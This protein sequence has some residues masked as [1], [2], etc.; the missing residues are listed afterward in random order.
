MITYL[1]RCRYGVQVKDVELLVAFLNDTTYS[2]LMR[3][4]K[5]YYDICVY[6]L[7]VLFCRASL[8][9][10][11]VRSIPDHS[12]ASQDVPTMIELSYVSAS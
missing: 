11:R 9:A 7:D 4:D 5:S 2:R 12:A 8:G 1:A 6:G 10:N 3:R